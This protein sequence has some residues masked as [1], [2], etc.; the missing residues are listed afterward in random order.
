MTVLAKCFSDDGWT[1]RDAAITASSTLI[2]AYPKELKHES[3]EAACFKLLC[4]AMYNVRLNAAKALCAILKQTPQPK[5]LLDKMDAHLAENI[6]KAKD[7][8]NPENMQRTRINIQGQYLD[9]QLY[10]FAQ[11]EMN[12][13]AELW[14]RSDGCVFLLHHLSLVRLPQN[15][16]G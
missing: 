11:Q 10:E 1:V 15:P 5:E 7:Q 6:L 16:E 2:A 4:D 3:F 9:K 8:Q 13:D 12:R 14:E